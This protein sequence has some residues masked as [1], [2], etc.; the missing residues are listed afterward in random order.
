MLASGSSVISHPYK[1]RGLYARDSDLEFDE[2]VPS[3]SSAEECRE[4]V[5]LNT[6]CTNP[7]YPVCKQLITTACD[8]DQVREFLL[9]PLAALRAKEPTSS[10][11]LGELSEGNAYATSSSRVRLAL[12]ERLNLPFHLHTCEES[13]LNTL[14][15][16]FFHMRCG[17]FVAFKEGKLA[18]FVPFVN[19]EYTNTWGA[20]LALE[21][22]G[23]ISA[24]NDVKRAVLNAAHKDSSKENLISDTQKWWAN[25][26][27]CLLGLT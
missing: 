12:Q 4:W 10:S 21:E 3:F 8:W 23:G 20:T 14:R 16:L 2:R 22:P 27:F 5:L 13:T 24:Y 9:E 26:K 15:Y 1:I 6:V 25:G 17:I 19:S 7:K 11:I 18:L